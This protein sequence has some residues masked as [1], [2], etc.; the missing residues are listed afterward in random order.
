MPFRDVHEVVGK[1]VAYLVEN[2]KG[3]ADMKIDEFKKFSELFEDDISRMLGLECSVGSKKSY[4]S[5]AP[6]LV[7]HQ[8]EKW[9]S[10]LT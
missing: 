1:I 9:K 5:T 3:F 10:K 4:G 7:K 8:I 2:G 6:E